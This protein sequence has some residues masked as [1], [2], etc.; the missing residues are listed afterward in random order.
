MC[1]LTGSAQHQFKLFKLSIVSKKKYAI[2]KQVSGS[3]VVPTLRS[4]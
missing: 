2:L 4:P 3:R 1:G